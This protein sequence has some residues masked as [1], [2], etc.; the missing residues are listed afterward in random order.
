M[1]PKVH[2]IIYTM[3]HHIHKLAVEVQKGLEASGVDAKIFQGKNKKK[4]LNASL[5]KKKYI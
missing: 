4:V 3:Y 1:A 5:Y 2:I